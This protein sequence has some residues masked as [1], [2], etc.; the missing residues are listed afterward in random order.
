MAEVI[1]K[2]ESCKD[3]PDYEKVLHVNDDGLAVVSSWRDGMCILIF[4]GETIEGD[5][6]MK[7]DK[8]R[9]LAK[10]LLDASDVANDLQKHF[11]S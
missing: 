11:K 4:R 7:P 9:D 5:V 1:Y 2:D 3:D 10:A 8:A 6:V